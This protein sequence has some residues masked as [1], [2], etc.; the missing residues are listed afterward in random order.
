MKRRTIESPIGYLTL[1]EEDGFLTR[2][3][4][5]GER[6]GSDRSELLMEAERQLQAYFAGQRKTFSLPLRLE[7]T[8]FQRRVWE[9]LARIPYGQTRSYADVARAIGREKASRAVGGA[10]HV[11]P[12]PVIVPCHR[13]VGADGSLTGYG[14]GLAIKEYLLRLEREN[15]GK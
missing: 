13:V 7:G 12:V 1:T 4:F 6:A 10:N 8:P 14:G 15:G 5:G 11:N 9:E 3:D 2:L